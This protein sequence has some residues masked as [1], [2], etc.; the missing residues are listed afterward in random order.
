MNAPRDTGRAKL[1][2]LPPV[3]AQDPALRNWMSAVAERLEVRE[4]TRGNPF[5]RA[6]TVR[7]LKEA[8]NGL[9]EITSAPTQSSGTI[10]IPLSNGLTASLAIDRFIES[11]RNTR[12]YRDLLRRLDDPNRF[13]DVV[14]EVRGVLLQS[15]AE[16]A[17][18]R[19]ADIRYVENKIQD[20]NRSL[21]V[22][23]REITAALEAN[24]AG[25]RETAYAFANTSSAQ[26]GKIA[27]LEASLGNYYQDGQPGRAVLEQQLGVF[28]D[29]INGLRAQYTLKVQAGGALAGFGIAATE[30]DGVPSSAFIIQADKFAIVS[31]NYSGGLTN[32]PDVNH[33]PFGVDS[34]GIYLNNNVYVRGSMRVDTGGKTLADGM[35]GSVRATA[36]GTAWSDTTARQ[37][38]WTAIGKTGSAPD[39]NH[40][41]IGDEVTIQ[42]ASPAFAET[43]YWNGTGWSNVGVVINGNLLV[44]GTVAAHKINTQGLTI[45]DANGNVIL[46]AGAGLPLQQRIPGLGSLA[47]KNSVSA[48]EVSGLGSLATR[49]D[50][51]VGSHVRFPDGSTMGTAD[52]VNRLSKIGSGNIGTF[53]DGLAV[54]EAYI[55]NAAISSAKIKDLAVSSLKIADNAVTIPA[56]ATGIYQA[57]V[58]IFVDIPMTFLM[59]GTFT[60]GDRKHRHMWRLMLNGV[61][62]GGETPDAGTLGAM[63]KIVSVQP[64][65]HTFTID[66]VQKTGDGRCGLSVFGSKK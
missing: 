40:L 37:A 43:R 38:V 21:A 44:D 59:I 15:I 26:A 62:L 51:F 3:N 47:T 16:E 8:T 2:A 53:M 39:N 7:E 9:V 12:L 19:G 48:T 5:E 22:A 54:T 55:G 60:Q 14:A 33:I 11:I 34:S 45:R 52:F 57:S 36:S 31:P 20:V 58:V 50:V 61:F 1:P 18:K 10:N 64:G 4:G 27:Q 65:T 63:T 35:R 49:G 46:D 32:S 29:R 6:V 23:V 41:V 30:V 25:V 28:A 42:N 66:C 56:G 13:D 17:A 24:S